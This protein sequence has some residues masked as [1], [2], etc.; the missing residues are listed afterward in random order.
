[1]RLV[2]SQDAPVTGSPLT[3]LAYLSEAAELTRDTRS[4]GSL[5]TISGPRNVLFCS[6]RD[7]ACIYLYLY[8]S[9]KHLYICIYIYI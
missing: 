5:D 6:S 2:R 9:D 3:P 4:Q 8:P 7:G 1:M